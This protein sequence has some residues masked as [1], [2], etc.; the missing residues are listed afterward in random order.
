MLSQKNLLLGGG[1][2][3][4]F[5]ENVTNLAVSDFKFVDVNNGN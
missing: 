4:G 2:W 5:S 3:N 1:Y